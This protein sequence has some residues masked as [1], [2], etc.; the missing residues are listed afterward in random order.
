MSEKSCTS[1]P[2]W[3]QGG[4]GWLLGQNPKERIF[5]QENVPNPRDQNIFLDL[6]QG[7]TGVG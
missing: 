6:A 7:F 1:C 5:S 2:N 4:G 3:G